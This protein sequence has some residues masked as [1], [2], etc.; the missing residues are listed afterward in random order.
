M[1]RVFNGHGMKIALIGRSSKDLSTRSVMVSA[2][3][4][5]EIEERQRETYKQLLCAT[6]R[7]IALRDDARQP[8]IS[9]HGV[10]APPVAATRRIM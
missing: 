5:P 7:R 10:P 3:E 1:R 4:A 8:R 6:T 2:S 9:E